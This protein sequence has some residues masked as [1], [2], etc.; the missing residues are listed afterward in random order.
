MMTNCL[1]ILVRKWR[2]YSRRKRLYIQST[3]LHGVIIPEDDNLQVELVFEVD[4]RP[5]NILT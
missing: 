2:L 1:N 4:Y 5:L 3:R